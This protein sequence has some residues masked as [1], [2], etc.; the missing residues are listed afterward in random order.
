MWP[1]NKLYLLPMCFRDHPLKLK[2]IKL[3]KNLSKRCQK[4]SQ[5]T[6]FRHAWLQSLTYLLVNFSSKSLVL[7]KLWHVVFCSYLPDMYV[8]RN[9]FM[10]VKWHKTHTVS[11][12]SSH[13]RQFTKSCWDI[14][15]CWK[16]SKIIVLGLPKLLAPFYELESHHNQWINYLKNNIQF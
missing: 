15:N 2:A 6:T 12:L 5:V 7:H 14:K 11:Y 9:S 1:Q 10:L 3:M 4:L 8:H 16:S 13:T